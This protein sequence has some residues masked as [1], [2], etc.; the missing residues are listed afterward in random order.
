MGPVTVMD[1][2]K[3]ETSPAQKIQWQVKENDEI[4]HVQDIDYNILREVFKD[5]QNIWG[6]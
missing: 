6:H 4:L 5:P 3:G 2:H 1:G